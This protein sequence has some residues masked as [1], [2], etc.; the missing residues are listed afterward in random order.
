MDTGGR[1]LLVSLEKNIPFQPSKELHLS[2]F[3][4]IYQFRIQECKAFQQ[5]PLFNCI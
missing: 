1:E 4:L 5:L 2:I 3:I